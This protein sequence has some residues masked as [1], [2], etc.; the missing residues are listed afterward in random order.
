MDVTRAILPHFR[1][2][3]NGGIVNI[4]T[5]TAFCSLP[6]ST[7]SSASKFALEGFTESLSYEAAS[8]GVFV[9]SVIPHGGITG[10]NFVQRYASEMPESTSNLGLQDY[11]EFLKKTTASFQKMIGGAA[12]SSDEVAATVYEA[13]T[14]G[15]DKLRYFIGNDARGFLK[16]RYNSKNDEEYMT[17]MRSFFK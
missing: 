17:Y 6:T 14:D 4:S 3:Q 9:K 15:T 10:N 12:T 2:N 5:G 11:D 8:Q 16:A 7:P 1:A 13:V